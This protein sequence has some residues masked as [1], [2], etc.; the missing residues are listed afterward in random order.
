MEEAL[1]EKNNDRTLSFKTMIQCSRMIEAREADIA[2]IEKRNMEV[3]IIDIVLPG[4]RK[5]EEKEIEKID[6]Y[7]MPRGD[8]RRLCYN[9]LSMGN[10]FL[11]RNHQTFKNN[12]LRTR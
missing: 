12:K 3:K 1:G 7:Q 6:K 8:V 10:N 2:F 4:D 5:V 11:F 9:Q